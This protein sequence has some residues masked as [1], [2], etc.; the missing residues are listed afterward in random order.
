MPNDLKKK[1]KPER[2][3]GQQKSPSGKEKL[4]GVLQPNYQFKTNKKIKI[5]EG[6]LSSDSSN[7]NGP[8][9]ATT[10]CQEHNTDALT[11]VNL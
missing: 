11:A 5:N 8:S 4:N 10:K 6:N 2:Q 1:R 7:I 9:T 3:S